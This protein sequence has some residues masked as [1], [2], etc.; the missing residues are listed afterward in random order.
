MIQLVPLVV[1]TVDSSLVLATVIVDVAVTGW[2]A[3][4]VNVPRLSLYP[5]EDNPAPRT[6]STIMKARTRDPIFKSQNSGSTLH[7]QEDKPLPDLKK[8][9]FIFA[10]IS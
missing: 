8:R 2:L 9:E 1:M 5:R 4:T 10:L 6:A 7:A 3:V